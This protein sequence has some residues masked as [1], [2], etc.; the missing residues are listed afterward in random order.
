MNAEGLRNVVA[1]IS[2]RVSQKKDELILLDQQ[3]GDGDL[4]ISMKDGFRAVEEGMAEETEKDLGFILNRCSSLFNEAAPSSLGT[5]LSFGFKGMAKALRGV[6]ECSIQEAGA[7]MKAGISNIMEKAGSKPGEKTILDSLCPG[8][9]AIR[10]FGNEGA[11]RAA[12]EAVKAARKGSEKTREMKAVW[13]RA[14]YYGERSIGMTDGGSVV[15]VL[16][17]EGICDYIMTREEQ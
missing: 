10:E 15:G 8:V 14:A 13:G 16:I 4:G 12:E 11:V 17:F 3:S 9:S 7:A 5:I 1:C 2:K 6:E